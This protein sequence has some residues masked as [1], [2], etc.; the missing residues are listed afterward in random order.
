MFINRAYSAVDLPSD[1]KS[2]GDHVNFSEFF[3]FVCLMAL[4]A[5]PKISF[6][7]LIFVLK[8]HKL[9]SLSLICRMSMYSKRNLVF[10]GGHS[11]HWSYELL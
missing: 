3:S 10:W 2:F 1:F 7:V 11:L 8:P 9:N 6:E 4:I 5:T